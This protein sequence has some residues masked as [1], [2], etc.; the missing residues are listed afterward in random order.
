MSEQLF[1]EFNLGSKA[2]VALHLLLF[3]VNSALDYF[4]IRED[5]LKVNCFYISCGTYF[6]VNVNDIVIFEATYN[7]NDSINLTDVRQELVAEAFTL[8]CAL[9]KTCNVNEFESC[10]C[11]FFGVVHLSECV[12]TFIGNG[13]YSHIWLNCAERVVCRFCSC[14]CKCIE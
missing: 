10:G 5:K 7:V 4:Y 9:H 2:L 13:Y 11:E 6:A 12:K 1:E 3:S 14:V 8:G